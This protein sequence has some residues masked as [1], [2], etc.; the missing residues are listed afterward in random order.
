MTEGFVK[1]RNIVEC[2]R[3]LHSSLFILALSVQNQWKTGSQLK[4]PATPIA[5]KDIIF[6]DEHL[7]A[8]NKPNGLLVHRTRIAEEKYLFANRLVEQLCGRPVFPVH[9]LDRATSGVLLFATGS[10]SASR[11]QQ[12]FAAG[13]VR[14]EYLAIV[15]GFVPLEGMINEPLISHESGRSRPAVTRFASLN[16]IEL[17]VAVGRYA[18]SRY[19]L[20][21]M[22]PQTGRTH[23]LRRHFNHLAHPIVGDTKYGD[24]RHNRMFRDQFGTTQMMLHA[25][26]LGFMHPVSRQWVRIS[27]PLPDQFAFLLKRFGWDTEP[28]ETQINLKR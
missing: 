27:A 26:A 6:Q 5:L 8:L 12:E 17:P 3:V 1:F 7:I 19:S 21:K 9:R 4:E 13:S 23:Q 16:T 15:R 11:L 25:H 18:T 14:K 28:I 24:L 20:V 2:I 10:D 22:E